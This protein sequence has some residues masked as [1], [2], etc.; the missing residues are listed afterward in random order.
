MPKKPENPRKKV[1]ATKPPAPSVLVA[2]AA[3]PITPPAAVAKRK[4]KATLALG[5]LWSQVIGDTVPPHMSQVIQRR[6]LAYA[7]QARAEGD[8][9]ASIAKRFD[10]MVR[11]DVRLPLS[12]DPAVGCYGSGMAQ[13]M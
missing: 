4:T 12:C 13:P 5:K 7:I 11:G 2:T 6:F 3:P 10:R 9:S 8:V 1:T